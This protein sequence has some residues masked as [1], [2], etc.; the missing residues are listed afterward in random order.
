MFT[1]RFFVLNGHPA[2]SSLSKSFAETYTKSAQTAGHKVRI[3]HLRDLDFDIDH[4]FGGYDKHKSLEPDLEAFQ[5]DVEWSQH[6]VL[7]TPM[8]WGGLPAKLKGLIDRTFLPEWAFDTRNLKMGMP[9]PLLKG[10]TARAIVTSDT[11]DQGANIPLCWHKT[12]K[13]YAFFTFHQG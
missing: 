1:K 13:G 4:G 2:Q 9:M 5:T 8:W 6:I 10:R 12:C 3:T 11:P 7:T